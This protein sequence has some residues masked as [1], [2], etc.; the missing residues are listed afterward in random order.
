MAALP[1]PYRSRASGRDAQR[2]CEDSHVARW[3]KAGGSPVVPTRTG[4]GTVGMRLTES[5]HLCSWRVDCTARDPGKV[6]GPSACEAGKTTG[7]GFS[8]SSTRLV[9]L[10]VTALNQVRTADRPA[11]RCSTGD[12]GRERP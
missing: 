2:G 8:I 9:K 12:A 1:L 10:A 7:D 11:A 6:A 5:R 4:T 3:P